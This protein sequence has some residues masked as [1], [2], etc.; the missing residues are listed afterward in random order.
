MRRHR[1]VDVVP[2]AVLGGARPARRQG[3]MD[4]GK[5]GP[6]EFI[7]DGGPESFIFHQE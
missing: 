7:S 6:V 2:R 3:G 5:I 1:A 4:M